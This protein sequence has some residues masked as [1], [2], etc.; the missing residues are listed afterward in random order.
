MSGSNG[1]GRFCGPVAAGLVLLG[2]WVVMLASLRD[3]SLTADEPGHV[4]AGLSYWR[5]N[6]YRMNPE[7]GNL[8]QRWMALPLLFGGHSLPPLDSEAWR[9]SDAANL[10][11]QLFY[12][13]GND[14]PGMLSRGR[15]MSGLLAVVLG[16]IV[17][18]WS[19]R[20]FGPAGG[21]LSLLLFVLD[22][23]VL[24]NGALM[25]S[26]TASAL[27]LVASLLG[28]WT[29]LHR[30]TPG[31]V[32]L[33]ALIMG[34]LFVSKMSAF[35]IVPVAV[36]LGMI[37][38]F[39]GPPPSVEFR[40]GRKL[41]T[42]GSRAA[43]FAAV[44]AVHVAVVAI[45]IWGSYGFRYRAF[46]DG[47]PAGAAFQV[48]W[49]GV[50][51]SPPA[52]GQADGR[53]AAARVFESLRTHR[54]L[55]EAYLYGAAYVWKFSRFRSGFLNGQV[56]LTGSWTFFPYTFLVKTP[57]P[58]FGV[59][60]LALAALRRRPAYE[61]L[62]LWILFVV[63]WAAALGSHLNIG[64]RHILPT[65][66]LLFIL[67]GAAGTWFGAPSPAAGAKNAPGVLRWLICGLVAALALESAVCF[68]NYL[69]Y[70]NVV[71]GGPANAYRHL[72]DSSLD[73]GQDLPSLKRY[74]GRH[75][76][77]GPAYLSYF[78]SASPDYYQIPAKYL[79][80]VRGR[81][82]PPEVQLVEFPADRAKAEVGQWLQR[83]PLYEAVGGAKSNDGEVAV[84]F[85]E[86][87]EAVKLGPGT[88]FISA[89][90]LQPIMYDLKGPL[91]PWNERYEQSYQLLY[92]AVKQLFDGDPAVRRRTLT[93]FE[94]SVWKQEL[95]YYDM[96]RFA[97]LT[98]Y[99][100]HLEPVDNIN[101]SIL[102]YRLTEADIG[103]A[104]D[105]PPPELGEDLS[106]ESAAAAAGMGGSQPESGTE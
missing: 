78:G 47:A 30:I 97:R 46:A 101:H 68:P 10:S 23:T 81:D 22:P 1:L 7:N 28:I 88:Y 92:T 24:A 45:V 9:G 34:G 99:L 18:W 42:P 36:A 95:A 74:I 59:I 67:C 76:S 106:A 39:A 44:A 51:G 16:A 49:A 13:P 26:D 65:Y 17:W 53:P 52:S 102:V 63:Y 72:V 2:F 6:D 100:R 38:L 15:A 57:L 11:D 48:P 80:A 71:A 96:Y 21:M 82:V 75:R 58:I 94:P 89:T 14:L 8:P 37:R 25:T 62:P 104:F 77:E 12:H 105:G 73:W 3:K 32:L 27:F 54:I 70:F 55:P 43:A 91:G 79:Y 4:A 5:F 69:T 19:R 50:L 85:L 35:L 31:R 56:G 98:A 20:L 83:H 40:G 103:L 84:M 93:S 60:L 41:A 61:T 64:H 86:K 33:S 66:P 29:V 90:M 87:P